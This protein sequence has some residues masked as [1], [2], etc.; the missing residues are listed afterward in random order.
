MPIASRSLTTFQPPPP[1]PSTLHPARPTQG[2]CACFAGYSGDDCSTLG[3]KPND[4]NG[5]V[6]INV[7]GI[8]DYSRSWTFLDVMKAGRGWLSQVR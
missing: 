1:P 6:G 3:P 4:C 5:E 8:A 2:K 7:E